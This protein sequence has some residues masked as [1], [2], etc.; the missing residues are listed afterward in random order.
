MY[1]ISYHLLWSRNLLR[2][3]RPATHC[4]LNVSMLPQ[5]RA[6]SLVKGTYRLSRWHKKAGLSSTENDTEEDNNEED[7]NERRSRIRKLPEGVSSREK[8]LVCTLFVPHNACMSLREGEVGDVEDNGEEDDGEEGDE[9]EGDGEE[10]RKSEE[11]DGEEGEDKEEYYEEAD[12]EEA[13]GEE[14]VGEA[15]VGEEG[16]D[17]EVF[18]STGKLRRRKR[19]SLTAKQLF[20]H[21][22]VDYEREGRVWTQKEV[23]SR[24]TKLDPGA[25][26]ICGS[27]LRRLRAVHKVNAQQSKYL[28]Q[29]IAQALRQRGFG[30]A[31]HLTDV[32]GI[33]T[34]IF[35][36][37]KKLYLARLK[38]PKV[39]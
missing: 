26:A 4:H 27:V 1:N 7:N 8:V 10:S 13:D 9:S 36:A 28:T 14:G 33:R 15:A 16:V 25:A 21:L 3:L 30:I 12:G 23:K 32:E 31:L 6:N 22:Q 18:A 38:N 19:A 35:Q 17:E 39:N 37:A 24:V 5:V 34:Q 11:D 20:R 2:R 29:G